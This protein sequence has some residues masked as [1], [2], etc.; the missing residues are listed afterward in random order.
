MRSPYR[1]KFLMVWL[2]FWLMMVIQRF[3]KWWFVWFP[4][5]YTLRGWFLHPY[6]SAVRVALNA[7]LA[8][9]S[10]FLQ[11]AYQ[12][13]D[14]HNTSVSINSTPRVFIFQKW[15]EG[16]FLISYHNCSYLHIYKHINIEFLCKH[17]LLND[18]KTH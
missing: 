2:V 12:Q 10:W 11:F 5:L 3:S 15:G 6:T 18:Y 7:F 8:V 1:P 14:I 16:L 9:F 4:C 17:S 13:T